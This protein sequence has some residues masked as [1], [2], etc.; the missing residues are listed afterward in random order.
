LNFNYWTAGTNKDCP[1]Q[2]SW[3]GTEPLE[4]LS[5]ELKWEKGQPDNKGGKEECLH[6][7]F[8]KNATGTIITDRNCSFKYIFACEVIFI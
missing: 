8:I 2:W 1:G 7:R 4:S 3:C 6:L 5:D